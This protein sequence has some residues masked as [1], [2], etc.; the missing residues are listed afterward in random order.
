MTLVYKK[1][2]K[3]KSVL[4]TSEFI[5]AMHFCLRGSANIA[6]LGTSGIPGILRTMIPSWSTLSL[7]RQ[8]KVK[9]KVPLERNVKQNMF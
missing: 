1:T 5:V 9:N 4:S 3:K 2:E 6:G 7:K 8:S